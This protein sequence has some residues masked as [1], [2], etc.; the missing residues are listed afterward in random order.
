[1]STLAE[2]EAAVISL[3]LPE[4]ERLESLLHELRAR[5]GEGQL[6]ELYRR[7]GFVPLP[8]RA[9]QPATC[10]PSH[11]PEIAKSQNA[12]FPSRF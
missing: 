9:G 3:T 10:R 1:M 7:I 6:E 2:I 12:S 5:Q 4:M 11:L 8:K